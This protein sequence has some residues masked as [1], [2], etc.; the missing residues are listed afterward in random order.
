MPRC[1]TCEAYVS[2]AFA[3]VLGDNDDRVRACL[4]CEGIGVV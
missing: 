3:R 4:A 2:P 1:R